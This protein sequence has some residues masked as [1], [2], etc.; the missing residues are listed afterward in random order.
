MTSGETPAPALG[1]FVWLCKEDQRTV[2][3]QSAAVAV[4]SEMEVAEAIEVAIAKYELALQQLRRASHSN[5]D[6]FTL[7][8]QDKFE[9]KLQ[10]LRGQLFV[11]EAY[12]KTANA[13]VPA[14]AKLG[15]SVGTAAQKL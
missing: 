9:Q 12:A 10:M 1:E 2:A 13:T 5:P 3:E 4:A 14:A 8:W 15:A 6:W 11:F 7:D